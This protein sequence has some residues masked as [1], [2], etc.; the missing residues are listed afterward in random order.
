MMDDLRDYLSGFAGERVHYVP[1]PGNAGDSVMSAA[2]F[3]AFDA[4][5]IRYETPHLGRFDPSRKVILY[6]GGGNL[7]ERGRHSHRVLHRLHRDAR[8]LTI[9]PHTIKDVDDLLDA[10]G[11]NVTVICRERPSYD[12]VAGRGGRYRTLLMHDLAFSLDVPTLM[13]DG[14]G[15]SPLGTLAHAAVQKVVRRTGYP[16]PEDLLR[17]IRP[18]RLPRAIAEHRGGGTINV[19]RLDGEATGIAIPP[20]NADLSTIFMYGVAPKPVACHATRSLLATLDRFDEVRTNRL[21]V[22]I[23][24]ALLGK[25]VLLHANNYYKIRAIYEFSLRDRYPNV[26]WMGEGT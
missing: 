18:P 9:L 15:Y 4:L 26:V 20:D 22:G 6:G 7:Y 21:H 19:F 12:Y 11:A 17:A 24:A 8:H 5:G 23:S 14:A 1:N 13:R 3:Q 2:T 16:A 10:F 25:R